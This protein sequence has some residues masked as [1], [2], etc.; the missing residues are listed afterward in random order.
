MRSAD[1][2]TATAAGQLTATHRKTYEV[3]SNWKV[4]ALCIAPLRAA[5]PS[6]PT[7]VL[8]AH[9]RSVVP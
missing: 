7:R 9:A 1:W 4:G 3:D 8:E 2:E 6:T 5:A